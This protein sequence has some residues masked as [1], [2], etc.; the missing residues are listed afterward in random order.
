MLSLNGM[1]LCT[2]VRVLKLLG[3]HDKEASYHWSYLIYL[4]PIYYYNLASQILVYVL[5]MIYIYN[6]FA[7]ADDVS[8]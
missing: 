2:K 6:C 7:N 1:V 5:V 8:I 3:E 4:Y